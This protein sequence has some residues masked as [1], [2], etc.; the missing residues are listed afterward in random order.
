M[1]QANGTS[2]V[3]S[4][5]KLAHVV[6]RTN[7]MDRALDFYTSFLGGRVVHRNPAL[8]FMTYDEEHHR[9]AFVQIPD[10]QDKVRNSNGLEHIA[11]TFDSL[12]DLLTAYKQRLDLPTPMKPVWCVN[13][14][15]TTSLV[16]ES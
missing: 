13:H 1:V 10:A 7:N 2:K 14:G 8:S 11:F 3:V 12:T 5:T 15:P 4:P 9:I 6:L 16:S